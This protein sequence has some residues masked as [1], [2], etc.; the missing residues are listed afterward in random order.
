MLHFQSQVLFV[1]NTSR[2]SFLIVRREAQ[3]GGGR[4]RRSGQGNGGMR[5]GKGEAE[6]G[7]LF[8]AVLSLFAVFL[9]VISPVI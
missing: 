3:D 7:Y 4:E 2:Y 8:F 1:E 5:L 6:R 9:P